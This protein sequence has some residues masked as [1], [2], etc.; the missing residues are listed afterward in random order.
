MRISDWSSDVCS[1]DLFVNGLPLVLVELKNNTSESADIWTA[2]DQIQTYKEQIPDVFH[3]NEI[4]LISDG[5][6]ARFGSLS[7]NAERFMQWRTIDG[8]ALDPLGQFNELETLVRGLLAPTSL[9]DYLRYF[10]LFEDDVT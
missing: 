1:S 3:Y 9:L 5:S 10:L 8:V 2:Y 6:E 7:V 4:L